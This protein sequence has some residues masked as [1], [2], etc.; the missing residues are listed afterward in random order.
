ML[1]VCGSTTPI[2][3]DRVYFANLTR[4]YFEDSWRWTYEDVQRLSRV[5]PWFDPPK[6]PPAEAWWEL[7]T[8]PDGEGDEET[9]KKLDG[10]RRRYWDGESAPLL[11]GYVPITPGLQEKAK[12]YFVDDGERFVEEDDE[13]EVGN[14][15]QNGTG[16][17]PS[18]PGSEEER[19]HGPARE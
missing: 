3:E 16:L 5:M 15:E 10:N 2:A 6:D 11:L 19:P 13:D 1:I 9:Q 14:G 12:S 8:S 7:V 17:G 4:W 18:P